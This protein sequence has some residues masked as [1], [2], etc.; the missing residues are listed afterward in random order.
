MKNKRGS[1]AFLP[2][3]WLCRCRFIASPKRTSRDNFYKRVKVIRQQRLTVC[4]RL[5]PYGRFAHIA[6]QHRIC[7][8]VV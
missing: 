3:T 7:R 2:K 4:M 5:P 8:N 1:P 6:S